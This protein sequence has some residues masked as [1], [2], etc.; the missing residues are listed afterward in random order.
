MK[1]CVLCGV[2]ITQQLRDEPWLQEFRAGE[3]ATTTQPWSE[4]ERGKANSRA[5]D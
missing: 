4:E 3:F 1:Y 5:Y 2:L